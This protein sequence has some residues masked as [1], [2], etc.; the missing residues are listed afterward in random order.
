MQNTDIQTEEFACEMQDET[1]GWTCG[2]AGTL[3][4]QE[5][6]FVQGWFKTAQCPNCEN[7]I[8]AE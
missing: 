5:T 3:E 2:F 6:R 1:M 4:Y 8:I 7:E